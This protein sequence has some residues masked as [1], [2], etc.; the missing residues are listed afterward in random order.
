M[1][2]QGVLDGQFIGNRL[3]IL[4]GRS[5]ATFACSLENDYSPVAKSEMILQIGSLWA[6]RRVLFCSF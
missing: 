3:G 6:E 4:D 1:V 5:T 2:L